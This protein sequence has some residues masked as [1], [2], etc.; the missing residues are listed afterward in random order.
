MSITISNLRHNIY[1]LIDEVLETGK[2]LEILRKGK[3][4]KI[5]PEK[6]VDRFSNLKPHP[7]TI[8]GDP[9]DLVHMDW[10]E[11]WEGEKELD[12]LS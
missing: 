12:D 7:N 11:Y 4:V 1:K 10:S 3:I 6:P 2:P 9:E 8:V 5:V